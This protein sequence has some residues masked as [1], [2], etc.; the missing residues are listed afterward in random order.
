MSGMNLTSNLLVSGLLV[1]AASISC[2]STRQEKA[3]A[4]FAE[5]DLDRDGRLSWQEFQK[6]AAA[7]RAKDPRNAFNTIDID[8]DGY[9]TKGELLAALKQRRGQ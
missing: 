8:H 9:L 7:S 3:A 1:A 4:R 5:K 2:A 6:T